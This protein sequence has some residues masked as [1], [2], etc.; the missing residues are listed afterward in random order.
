MSIINIDQQKYFDRV[1]HEYL[2]RVL[3]AFGLGNK[4]ISFIKLCDIDDSSFI[5]IN[6][7][8]CGTGW[9]Y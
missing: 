4:F 2:F 7:N 6:G 9:W 5:N 8:V 1:H 3:K